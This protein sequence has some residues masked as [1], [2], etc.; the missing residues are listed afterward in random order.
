MSV[1]LNVL[2]CPHQRRRH[3]QAAMEKIS[4]SVLE[5]F[6][7]DPAQVQWAERREGVLAR[8]AGC[9]QEASLP[10]ILSGWLDGPV[11]LAYLRDGESWG[12]QLHYKGSPT[13]AFDT[14]PGPFAA[15]DPPTPEQRAARLALY[16][17]AGREDIREYLVPWTRE[18]LENG[19]ALAYPSDLHPRGD[20]MQLADFLGNLA[21]W[22]R[23]MLTSDQLAPTETAPVPDLSS[24]HSNAP[25]T[26]AGQ[27]PPD[28][29][30][31]LEVC[32]PFLTGVRGQRRTPAFPL[33]LFTKKRPAPEDI[34]CEG[35]TAYELS[36][37]LDRFQT[38]KLDRLELSFTLQG[39][40]TF[41]RRLRKTVYQPFQLTLELIREGKRCVCLL[42]DGEACALYFL[43]ADTH[44]YCTVDSEDLE[45]V[46]FHGQK[47]KE[48]VVF[49]EPGPEAV[50]REAV[51]LLSRLDRRDD[52]LSALSRNGVWSCDLPLTVT[53]VV[54]QRYQELRDIW[55]IPA[56]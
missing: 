55:T 20:G 16:F 43:V 28:P 48:Y 30:P 11:L 19:G 38:G 45:Q 23:G 34:P 9:V 54:R 40:G 52:A 3:V 44:A 1:F 4:P 14:I 33:S 7:L 6:Q 42:L 26:E 25:D 37:V 29:E 41:V 31:G 51:C 12:Y 24:P 21:P 53:P 15:P 18:E 17:T 5:M 2:I 10:R 8:W 56:G 39:K 50:R 36:E 47:V 35:W 13:D 22:T 27:R 32:L 46:E 49:Q